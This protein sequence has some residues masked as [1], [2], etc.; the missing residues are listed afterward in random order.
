MIK[1]LQALRAKK[2]FTLVELIVVIA[3][4]GVLA[5]I[6]IPTF[7]GVIENA[8]KRSVETTCQ[9]LQS[10]AKAYA[11]QYLSDTGN[12]LAGDKTAPGTPVDMGEADGTKYSSFDAYA[13]AQIPEL[14]GSTPVGSYTVTFADGKVSSLKYTEGSYEC[15]YTATGGMGKANKV[16]AATPTP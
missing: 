16:G 9:S 4:I 6:L 1:K 15:E 2:G 11:S 3:I 8:K 13:L 7:S 14:G 12:L 5:A 10:L